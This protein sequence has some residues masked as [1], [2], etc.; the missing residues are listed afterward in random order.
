MHPAVADVAVIGAPN[1]EFGEEVK[2]V[3]QLKEGIAPTDALAR[4]LIDHCRE[5]V[6]HVSTPRSVDF[7]EELPRLPTGKLAKHQLRSRYWEA[8]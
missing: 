4:E 6:S 5:R 7:V 3:V 1:R 8:A 2:A